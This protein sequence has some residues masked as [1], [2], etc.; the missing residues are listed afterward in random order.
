MWQVVEGSPLKYPHRPDRTIS[1]RVNL[2]NLGNAQILTIPGEALPNIG[3]YL[4]RQMPG[5]HNFLFGEVLQTGNWERTGPASSVRV[6][7]GYAA[8]SPKVC[9]MN[10]TCPV[11]SP[12][13]NHRTCPLR[14]MCIAS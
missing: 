9:L 8:F 6:Q 13:G 12:L 14:I 10:S 7:F 11:T 3:L 4:K 5:E 1:T 2:V